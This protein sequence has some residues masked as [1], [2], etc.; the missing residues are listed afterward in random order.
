M[1]KKKGKKIAAETFEKR[2]KEEYEV[3]QM[4]DV[5]AGEVDAFIVEEQRTNPRFLYAYKVPEG[6]GEFTLILVYRRA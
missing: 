1:A 6:D 2:P 3:R 4:Q 5:P